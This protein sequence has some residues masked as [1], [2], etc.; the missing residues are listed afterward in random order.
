MR[1]AIQHGFVFCISAVCCLCG[2]CSC[3]THFRVCCYSVRLQ[4][5]VQ[6][7]S[8]PHKGSA[9]PSDLRLFFLESQNG[10]KD[11]AAEEEPALLFLCA[12]GK[13]GIKF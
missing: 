3:V 13:S 7:P 5:Q 12:T 2:V 10:H 6:A 8:V 11:R 1:R 4:T 9:W